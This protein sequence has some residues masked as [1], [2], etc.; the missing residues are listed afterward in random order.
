[1]NRSLLAKRSEQLLRYGLIGVLATGAHY[2]LMALLVKMGLSPLV[3]TTA[4]ATLGAFVAYAANRKWTF[5]AS[6]TRARMIR[7]LLVACFGLIL[8]GF[9]LV[10]LLEWLMDSLVFAQLIT[11]GLVFLATFFINL[12]WSFR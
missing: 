7:F 11:T 10:T 12:K 1:M 8:N 3:S 2:S 4:G 9:L 5:E 6:H